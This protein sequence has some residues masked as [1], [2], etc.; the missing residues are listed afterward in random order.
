[1][2]LLGRAF[3]ISRLMR[4]LHSVIP[5]EHTDDISELIDFINDAIRFV[6]IDIQILNLA[7]LQIYCSFLVL[8]PNNSIVKQTFAANIP[9]WLSLLSGQEANWDSCRRLLGNIH[10]PVTNDNS[11]VYSP[12]SKLLCF[13]SM[14]HHLQVWSCDTGE[15]IHDIESEAENY[16]FTYSPTISPNGK[17]V[18]VELEELLDNHVQR[19]LIFD[20]ITG[21]VLFKIPDLRS[22]RALA[23]SQDS[24]FIWTCTGDGKVFVWDFS[25]GTCVEELDCPLNTTHDTISFSL[26]DPKTVIMQSYNSAYVCYLDNNKA[27]TFHLTEGF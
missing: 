20:L 23:F 9:P 10:D 1:M 5:I 21:Q 4:E 15:C 24:K 3:Q 19:I 13:I 7:P 18:A 6:D 12:D 17:L 8:A 11:M 27:K 26:D 14:K 22:L 2:S 25:A 16:R